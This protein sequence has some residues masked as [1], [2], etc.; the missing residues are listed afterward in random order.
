M[1]LVGIGSASPDDLLQHAQHVGGS[2]DSA[3]NGCKSQKD[4]VFKGPGQYQKF[5]DK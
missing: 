3:G 1:G 5:A 4:I 2:Q